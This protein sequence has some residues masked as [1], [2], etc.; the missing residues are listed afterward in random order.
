ML[1]VLYQCISVAVLS[2][3]AVSVLPSS[4]REKP[5]AKKSVEAGTTTSTVRLYDSC[6]CGELYTAD[7]RRGQYA[8]L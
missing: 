8:D 6:K 2:D 3:R 7:A 1:S 4:V 5:F